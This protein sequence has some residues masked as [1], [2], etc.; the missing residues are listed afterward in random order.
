MS[1][2]EPN[3]VRTI[4]YTIS[5]PVI[6]KLK[7]AWQDHVPDIP[8]YPGDEG[9]RGIVMCAGRLKYF[10]CAWIAIK[11]LR[12]LDCRLP[13]E[14]WYLGNELS[15][16]VIRELGQYDVRCRNFLDDGQATP[17]LRGCMLKPLCIINSRFR[18]V[19]F[20]DADNICVK[21]PEALFDS[22]AYRKHGAIFWPDFWRTAADNPIWNITG[23]PYTETYEQESGQ[24][25]IDRKRCWTALNLAFY[26][27]V[28]NEIYYKLVMGD[29]DT[30]RYAW[31]ALGQSFHMMETPVGTCGYYDNG[32]FLGTTMVQHDLSGEIMFLHRNLMKWSTTHPR[33]MCWE[34]I[35]YFPPEAGTRIYRFGYSERIHNYM[36]L[37]GEYEEI[38]FREKFGDLEL[39]CLKEL[40]LLRN[41]D[42]YKQ[43][44]LYSHFAETRYRIDHTFGLL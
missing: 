24:I 42:F 16:D 44:L 33:E 39:Q 38:S 35:K 29:K 32:N 22:G 25:I 12:E 41:S 27:N 20:L 6:G 18:E 15:P 34:K 36:D 14:L 17:P 40:E 9:E 5:K 26:F 13:V 31:L 3:G 21:D 30:F 1:N 43:F 37:Q 23:T 8:P 4:D 2:F 19:F 10:T 7:K 11:R 28:H